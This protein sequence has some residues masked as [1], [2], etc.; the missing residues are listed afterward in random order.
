MISVR[1]I[2]IGS[3]DYFANGE[4]LKTNI[5]LE[6]R[7][8]SDSNHQSLRVVTVMT[9]SDVVCFFES[10]QTHIEIDFGGDIHHQ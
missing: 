7:K 3:M 5:R 9:I 8:T 2:T 6:S 4:L 1:N 10:L